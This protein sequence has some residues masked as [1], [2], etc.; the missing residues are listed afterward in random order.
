M[1]RLYRARILNP[2][3]TQCVTEYR[4]G[5][6]VVDA[7]GRILAVG[8][9]ARVRPR[10]RAA[11]IV[12]Y[13]GRLLMP[14]LVDTHIH[15][16][17][18]D[19]RGKHGA[20]LLDW[21]ERYIFSAE[22]RFADL[23]V[24]EDISRRFFKKLILNGTT[25]SMV[26]TTIHTQS[27]AL[28]FGLAMASGLRVIMGKVMMDQHSP[29]SLQEATHRSLNDSA[30]L[31]S[32]WDGMAG[33]RIRYAFTPRF[34]P[35]CSETLMRETGKLVEASGAYLQTH[36]AETVAENSAVKTLF[37]R[38]HDYV[39]L[40]E[41]TQCLGPRHLFA[42]AIHLS[43]SEYRR[44]ARADAAIAHC[45]LSNLFLKS[46]RMPIERVEQSGVKWGLG[47][48]VGA[49]PSMSMF[50]VMRHADYIQ[51]DRSVE[52]MVALH[53]ATR[54]GAE[55]LG[56]DRETGSFAKGKWAD[57]IVIDIA[58]IDPVYRLAELSKAEVLS[59]LMYRGDG[60]AIESTYVAGNK[61]DVDGF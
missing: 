15:L 32:E 36:I 3:R 31:C 12:H 19:Q 7:D 51:P 53:R 4:D 59:L 21:L 29:K 50:A 45:P 2:T 27:T 40:F 8:S 39:H 48:D 28:A 52:P 47:T 17:Q 6:L 30:W 11:K 41:R 38:L 16:P 14:G 5:A 43:P 22:S 10:F 1:Q 33:G 56:L 35:T 20:T 34:A 60:Q 42:H 13:A 37:P 54:G 57:F 26:F 61:L 49:G 23:S 24:A 44:L 55:A 18:L 9:Y 25:T 46:G 58:G